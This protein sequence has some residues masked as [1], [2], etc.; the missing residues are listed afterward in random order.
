MQVIDLAL[1]IDAD[2]IEFA[3]DGSAL[4]LTG[5]SCAKSEVAR[6]DRPSATPIPAEPD[7]P[8]R[9]AVIVLPAE[10]GRP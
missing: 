4:I 10:A 9:Y 1:P 5:I 3:P 2:R 8:T 7:N 6:N